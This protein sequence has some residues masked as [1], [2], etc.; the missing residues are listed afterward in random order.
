[1]L[2]YQGLESPPEPFR[3]LGYTKYEAELDGLLLRGTPDLHQVLWA[4]VAEGGEAGGG[5]GK[6]IGV[7]SKRMSIVAPYK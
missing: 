3:I 4:C 6:P 7:V 5:G 2:P 1:M